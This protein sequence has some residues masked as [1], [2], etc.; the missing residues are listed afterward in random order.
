MKKIF[1]LIF[2]LL[3]LASCKTK[4]AVSD[5][6]DSNAPIANNAAFFKEI[7]KSTD[8]E[9]LK[10]Q[11]KLDVENGSF[12][13]TLNA[14]LYIEKGNKVWLN[15]SALFINVARGLAT[16][17]GIKAYEIYNKTYIDSD[18]GYLN[19]LLNV[20][21]ID[22][23]S[24]QN[25]L[26]GKTFIPVNE[27]DFKLVKSMDGYKLTSINNQKIVNN[28]T[29]SEYKIELNY[30]PEF[31]LSHVVLKDANSSDNLEVFYSNWEN[32]NNLTLPKNVKIVI[33]GQ[34]KSE[35]LLENNRFEFS[36]MTTPF[37]VPNNYQKTVIK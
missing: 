34:K 30:N 28:G 3:I 26:I 5:P 8:F 6:T 1:G 32:Q 31:N 15:L 10:I 12:I 22:L 14:T 16:K 9:A 25:L 36:K 4:T 21:F 17:D 23:N 37:T 33:N 20:N 29:T 27:N 13:P 19:K 18:F 35:I 24:F 2:C 11:S 7:T